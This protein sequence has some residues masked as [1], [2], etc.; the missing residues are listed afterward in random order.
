VDVAPAGRPPSDRLHDP[1]L[2]ARR[3]GLELALEVG[4][5]GAVE[6]RHHR[7]PQRRPGQLAHE[8]GVEQRGVDHVGSPAPQHPPQLHRRP[9]PGLGGLAA[10]QVERQ[11]G[12]GQLG[13]LAVE[14]VALVDAHEDL[15]EPLVEG[16]HLVGEAVLGPARSGQRVDDVHHPQLALAHREPLIGD[17]SRS[18]GV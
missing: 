14:V 18:A 12:D 15:L 5:A 4:L 8:V 11:H 1:A 13:Q 2:P 3:D 16:D 7:D 10:L 17:R 9:R 6:R